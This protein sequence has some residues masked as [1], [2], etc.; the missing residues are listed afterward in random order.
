MIS[1][2]ND[3]IQVL[4]KKQGFT[5]QRL[6]DITK[7]TKGY[8]SKVERSKKPPPFSTLNKIAHALCVDISQLLETGKNASG[9]IEV[10]LRGQQK[11]FQSAGG[12]S[13]E[14][15]LKSYQ[16]RYMAPVL[17]EVDKGTTE[18]LRHDGEE[19]VYIVSG[20]IDLRYE[21]K[22]HSLQMR[23]CFYLDSRIDHSFT[24]HSKQKA[25]L[26]AVNFDY[27]RF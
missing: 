13:F 27:R 22:T 2:I 24:N 19:F 3:R 12:Y 7:L 15:L 1:P 17:M 4:R 9:N 25:I 8:L 10:H 11:M 18:R 5:L 16:N 21:N 14:P 6:A 20:S 26:L 23:D